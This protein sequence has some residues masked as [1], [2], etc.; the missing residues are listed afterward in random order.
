MREGER[1]GEEEEGEGGREREE[2]DGYNL[3]QV[4][5]DGDDGL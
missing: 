4:V 5:M 2:S 3:L 1:Q